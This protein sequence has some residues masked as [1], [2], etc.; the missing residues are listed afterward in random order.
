MSSTNLEIVFE[1]SGV[2]QGTINARLLADALIG[3]S[4]VFTRANQIVNG[5]ASEAVVLVQSDFKRGSFVVDVQLVQGVVEH[6]KHLI[7]SH[8]FL[9]SSS[10]ASII[11]FVSRNKDSLIDLYK[12]LK[13]KKP[14]KIASVKDNNYEVT[15]GQNKK[16]VSGPVINMYG[17]SAIQIAMEK[18][19]SPLR[20][21]DAIDRIA[22]SRMEK[23]NPSSN[24]KKPGISKKSHYCWNQVRRPPRESATPF[25]SC[26][27]SRLPKAPLGTSL[28]GGPSSSRR[29]KTRNSGVT[30]INTG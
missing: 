16:T 9:S 2:R 22:V 19:T 25:W 3:C 12:W 17:D 28:N 5:E 30:F 13:G 21:G 23:S 26:Q 29:F 7:T 15:F 24:G 11:G 6:A 4:D 14:D 27:N 1:G 10:L 8:P 20:Q 18:L